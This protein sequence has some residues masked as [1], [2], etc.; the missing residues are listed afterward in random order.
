MASRTESS[1]PAPG[2]GCFS[3]TGPTLDRRGAN[4]SLQREVSLNSSLSDTNAEKGPGNEPAA[5]GDGAGANSI[6]G[7]TAPLPD[8]VADALDTEGPAKGAG[9]SRP[10]AVTA[11]LFRE[12]T[13]PHRVDLGE[14]AAL[15]SDDAKFVWIDLDGYEPADLRSVAQQ[16]DLPE[17]GVRM[18]LSG[19]ERPRLSVFG[20]RYVAAVTVPHAKEG[21]TRVLA[22]ELDLF[23]GRNYLVSAH[24]QPLPFAGSA[25]T[26][27]AQ[28]PPL[29]AL[30]SAFLL[31]I[32]IDELLAHYEQMTEGLEDEIEGLEERALTDASDEFLEELLRLKRFVFATH[33]LAA[34]HR[35][36]LEAFLRPD[37]PLVGGDA[38][39]PYLR[40]LEVR[41]D[42]VLDALDAARD[43]VN[44]TFDLYVS[45]VAHQTNGIMK[46][47]TIVSVL[48][49]PATV[50]LGFFGTS[51]QEPSITSE[52][53]FVVMIL[54]IV[55]T[56]GGAL[57]LF[58]RWGWIGGQQRSRR[59]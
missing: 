21:T 12:G 2:A 43:G 36:L 5:P 55:L 32:L 14:V 44:G 6:A 23:V 26:R 39:E 24:K 53:G 10:G 41:L 56:T 34:Q 59:G 11:W 57:L 7:W 22:S 9:A 19:W 30:D 54:L 20:D 58:H 33:R 37:F 1:W 17:A 50:I 16:L 42:R 18:A 35:P 52:A 38:I 51:F 4:H 40:D 31:S 47:L 48:L 28:N 15:A 29:L 46:V 3:T 25:L 13:E 45:R 27:A 8:A 49:L